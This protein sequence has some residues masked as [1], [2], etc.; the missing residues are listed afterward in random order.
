MA[1]RAHTGRD[2]IRDAGMIKWLFVAMAITAADQ[3]VA[4]PEPAPE[5]PSVN[6][7]SNA[8]ATVSPTTVAA[9]T[10]VD[11]PGSRSRLD[12]SLGSSYAGGDFGAARNTSLFTTALGVR[13][14]IGNIRL[15]A[16][17]PYM[18]LRSNGIF[19]T[20]IDSTPIVVARGTG[21]R[22]TAKGIG[23]VT[24]GASYTLPQETAGVE[25]EFSGRVKIP[26]AARSTGLSSRKTDYSAGVQATK[27][28]GRIAP[29]ASV[30][31]RIFGD[32]RIIELRNGFA[33]S[34]GS[35]YVVDDK[36]VLLASYHY[37]RAASRL[38]ANAH[39]LFAG[40]SR[41]M[42]ADRVRLTAYATAGLSSGAAAGSGGLSVSLKL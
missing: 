24:L 14:A 34:A 33:A 22:V 37:A 15:S 39:E 40:A 13:Y 11:T 5:S 20:G 9:I 29:F 10:D 3:A 1:R 12:V 27:T 2:E 35:S 42:A 6:S 21:P 31:Y 7:P 26:T 36:T 18:H 8:T 4:A 16:S 19:F 32:P 23:D 38:I 28:I 41:S 30:T 25:L 17:I